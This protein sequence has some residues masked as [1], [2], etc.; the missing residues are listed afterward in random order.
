MLCSFDAVSRASSLLC[1]VA[2]PEGLPLAVT[3]ALAFATR[4]MTSQNLLV[5]VLSS[6][7]IMANANVICTDKTG[8]LTQNKMSVVA[9]SI[10][11]HCK[12]VESLAEHG[13]RVNANDDLKAEGGEAAEG[14][15]APSASAP[16]PRREG[17]LDFSAD[18]ADVSK[19]INP[20]LRRLFNESVALNSNAFE[21]T[22]EHGNQGFV[23]SKTETA[24][25]AFC[26][27]QGWEPYQQVRDS[28][29]IVQAL[30]FDSTRKASAVVAKLPNGKFRFYVKGASEILQKRSTKHVFIA[31]PASR[32][33][34]DL[35]KKEL[36]NEDAQLK[37]V[38][39]TDET[40]ANVSLISLACL[41]RMSQMAHKHTNFYLLAGRTHYHFLRQPMPAD[42]CLVLPRLLVLAAQRS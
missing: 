42:Y 14:Q 37:D 19:I 30:P 11:V 10:G 28:K 3:V 39:F 22:D 4:R 21:G 16:P 1:Q 17:R 18:M 15:E 41:P 12:F 35:D 23:G 9:G 13:D 6:C 40:R 26:K 29:E 20:A 2:V 34:S 33:F 31:N 7:E 36:E 5:R 32:S 24:L 8:T 25:L 38:E 27:E